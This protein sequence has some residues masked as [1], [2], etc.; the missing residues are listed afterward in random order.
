MS[1]RWPQV[2]GFTRGIRLISVGVEAGGMTESCW[3]R[4]PS[5]STSGVGSS[6]KD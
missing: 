2:A 5:Q 1:E 4:P 3:G 6:F